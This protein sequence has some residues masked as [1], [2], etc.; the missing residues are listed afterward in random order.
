MGCTASMFTVYR[1]AVWSIV[2]KN[3]EIQ[4]VRTEPE[5]GQKSKISGVVDGKVVRGVDKTPATQE[6]PSHS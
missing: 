6:T 5:C 2:A 1:T 4:S 3:K